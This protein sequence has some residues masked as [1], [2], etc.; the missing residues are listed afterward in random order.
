MT[1]YL[2]RIMVQDT[3]RLELEIDVKTEFIKFF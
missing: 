2:L 1:Q 3:R